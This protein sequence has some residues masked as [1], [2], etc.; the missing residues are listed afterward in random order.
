MEMI[1]WDLEGQD[2]YGEINFSYL[3]GVDGL[4]LVA[5]GTRT[6]SLPTCL[7]LRDR[8]FALIGRVPYVLLIN[9]FDIKEKWGLS[10]KDILQLQEQGI[11][12]IHTSAKASLHIEDA[13]VELGRLMLKDEQAGAG[14]L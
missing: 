11:P 7:Q 3:R 5:D 9:K 4:L 14:A 8:A 6:E 2:A 10:V 12:I 13:F 1:V